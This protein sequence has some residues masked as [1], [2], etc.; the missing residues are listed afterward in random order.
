[1]NF[2]VLSN[3]VNYYSGKELSSY[4]EEMI[5][6]TNRWLIIVSPYVRIS[7]RIKS[8]FEKLLNNKVEIILIYRTNYGN[9]QNIRSEDYDW[10]TKHNIQVKSCSNLHAKCYINE[11]EALITSI[12]LSDYSMSNNFEQGVSFRKMWEEDTYMDILSDII[13]L[14]CDGASI[15]FD[16]DKYNSGYCIRTGKRIPFNIDK[17]MCDEAWEEWCKYGNPDYPEK[18]CHYSG[19]ESNGKTCVRT[20]ILREYYYSRAQYEFYIPDY[21]KRDRSCWKENEQ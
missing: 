9:T 7:G 5:E 20:P 17:P 8:Y 14:N 12:N 10:L 18:Y 11:C 6:K 4:L 21:K 15:D 13:E 3:G 2:G 16:Y 1:M 19:E